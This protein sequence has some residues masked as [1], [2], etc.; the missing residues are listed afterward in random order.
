MLAGASLKSLQA[1]G[2]LTM[3]VFAAQFCKMELAHTTDFRR[4]SPDFSEPQPT[5]PHGDMRTKAHC[6]AREGTQQS[7]TKMTHG[8][9]EQPLEARP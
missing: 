3:P 5:G 6:S 8:C 4:W 9:Y 7:V 1:E 2:Q